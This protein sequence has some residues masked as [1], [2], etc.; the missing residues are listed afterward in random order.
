MN[1]IRKMFK[2]N[3]WFVENSVTNESFSRKALT[4]EGFLRKA[5]E[6]RMIIGNVEMKNDF[7]E[8][9]RRIRDI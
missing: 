1:D 8:K 4:I 6:N 7:Q 9:M 2:M 5:L 3:E